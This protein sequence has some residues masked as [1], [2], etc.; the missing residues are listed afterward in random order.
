MFVYKCKSCAQLEVGSII[1]I[2]QFKLLG[3]G[4]CLKVETRLLKE[5]SVLITIKN[6]AFGLIINFRCEVEGGTQKFKKQ[7]VGRRDIS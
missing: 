3:Y 1:I 4:I 5:A 6:A 7:D 2:W